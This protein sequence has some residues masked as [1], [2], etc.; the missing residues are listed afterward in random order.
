MVK[1]GTGSA[2]SELGEEGEGAF[3][4]GEAGGVDEGG[5]VRTDK[6]VRAG[7]EGLEDDVGELVRGAAEEDLED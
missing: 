7:G 2:G 5:E 3:D 4:G 1:R 6:A